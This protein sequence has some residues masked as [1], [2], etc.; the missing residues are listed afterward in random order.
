MY[1]NRYGYGQS[2]RTRVGGCKIGVQGHKRA[3]VENKESL[4]YASAA[5]CSHNDR[6]LIVMIHQ[7]LS[8]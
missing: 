1:W 7:T 2:F 8:S 4:D 5:V 3:S 6:R